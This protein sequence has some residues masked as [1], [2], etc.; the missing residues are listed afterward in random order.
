MSFW[1]WLEKP[2][3]FSFIIRELT[4]VFVGIFAVLT[5]LQ[6][7]ALAVG[8]DAYTAFIE[9]LRAPGFILLNTIGL[10]A[11]LFH[12]VTWFKAVPTTMI[13]RL[14]ETRVPGQVIVGLHYVGWITVSA[15]VAWI[16]LLR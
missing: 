15:V 4:C 10:G 2:A 5:L 1:W 14:G 11:L 7:R 9:R 13:V 16:L 12:A 8:P 3:Y 6:I